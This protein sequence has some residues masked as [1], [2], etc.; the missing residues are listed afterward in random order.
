VFRSGL[1]IEDSKRAADGI[2]LR[3]AGAECMRGERATSACGLA[4][5]VS[6]STRKRQH[7]IR[8]RQSGAVLFIALIV[9]V[10]MTLAGIAIMRSVDTATLIAGNL[11]FKQGTIQ[12]SDNGIEQA[13]QW[14]LA[15]R[16]ALGNDDP[17]RGYF[18]S[19]A[20]PNWNDPAQWASAVTIGTDAAGNTVSYLIHR[21]CT[22]PNT[23]YNGTCGGVPNQCALTVPPT[24]PPP[25][26]QGDSFS[27]GAPGF[28]QDPQVYYRITVRSVGPRNTTSY[29][30]AMV[31][32]AL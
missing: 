30:Q 16:A 28:L 2:G 26:A 1:R 4:A 13:Y 19:Q 21:M 8:S 23:P 18:S 12:S 9:L 17:S 29:V 15:N 22:C 3:P 11:A 10:A 32:I 24:T 20:L 31:A 25:P 6:P 5:R 27:V 14:L 7:A